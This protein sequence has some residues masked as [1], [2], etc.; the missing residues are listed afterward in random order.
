MS[1]PDSF[2]FLSDIKRFITKCRE[3]WSKREIEAE[4]EL[5]E[6][7]A[8]RITPVPYPQPGSILYEQLMQRLYSDPE[9]IQA[10]NLY[11]ALSGNPEREL[12]AI[13]ELKHR[14]LNAVC[15]Q[16]RRAIW[17]EMCSQR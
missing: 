15:M 3:Y 14:K 7:L 13:N 12:P 4:V 11:I 2:P 16:R 1:W 17:I 9:W 8:C 5:E 10:A 6:D